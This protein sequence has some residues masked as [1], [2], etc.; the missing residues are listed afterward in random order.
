MGR[1]AL[2]CA[3][4]AAASLALRVPTA[5]PRNVLLYVDPMHEQ[6]RVEAAAQARGAEVVL[7]SQSELAGS[8]MGDGRIV[9]PVPAPGREAAWAASALPPNAI[10]RGVLTG[11]DSALAA[12]E[13]LAHVLCPERTNGIN[14]LCFRVEP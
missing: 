11:E 6:A 2:L 14:P 1:V 5:P 13:R 7:L 4:L 12:S 9:A 8:E 10:V 3:S